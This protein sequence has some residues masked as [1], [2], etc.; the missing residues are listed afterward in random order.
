MNKNEIQKINSLKNLAKNN[1]KESILEIQ[2]SIKVVPRK[3][4]RPKKVQLPV[5]H[6]IINKIVQLDND[7]D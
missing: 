2:E 1:K 6:K 7:Y 5:K 4:G 3:R